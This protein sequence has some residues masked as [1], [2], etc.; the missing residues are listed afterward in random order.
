M[1]SPYSRVFLK[2]PLPIITPLTIAIIYLALASVW[3]VYSD[4]LL[5]AVIKKPEIITKY[6]TLKGLFFVLA[7]SLLIFI[8]AKVNESNVVKAR[9]ETEK[10]VINLEKLAE[11]SPTGILFIEPDGS[12]RFTN[13]MAERILGIDNSI[14][15]TLKYSEIDWGLKTMNGNEISES[16]RPFNKVLDTKESVFG[17]KYRIGEEG[18]YK[19]ISINAAPIFVEGDIIEGIACAI[20]DITDTV[21]SANSVREHKERYELLVDESP[22][23]VVIHQFNKIIS[24]NPM[25]LKLLQAES[26]EELLGLN[27]LEIIAPKYIQETLD[28]EA[29]FLRGE[30]L[31]FPFEMEIKSVKGNLVPIEII[32]IPFT[33]NNELAVQVVAI[34]ISDRLNKERSLE[35]ALAEKNV[36]L[37]E[38]HHR[39]K[40]NMA[41]ISGLMQLQ[42][43]EIEDK[44]L[45]GILFDGV[46]RIKTIA[47]IHEQLY[48]S[49]NF[50]GIK[51]DRNLKQMVS[52]V[53]EHYPDKTNL[54]I[55]YELEP[56]VLNI[57]QAVS[58]A[59]FINEAMSNLYKY[60]LEE[61]D[62]ATCIVGCNKKD[63]IVRL[64]L[65][66]NG[67]ESV[68][69]KLEMHSQ[70]LSIQLMGLMAN[71][72]Y[73]EMNLIK[74]T[75]GVLIEL[76]FDKEKK[77]KG[78]SESKHV[79]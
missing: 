4:S 48:E 6:Q 78:S 67:T 41:I 26:E 22:F 66:I 55:C 53:S 3:I 69:E 62:D 79:S 75:A 56:I 14:F 20:S 21:E 35:N 36:L 64:S 77:L 70:K 59:L 9:K 24:V 37:S 51:L 47:L 15:S 63:G 68:E 72:L 52:G 42:A 31:S 40:N 73:G 34:D 76:S 28:R 61:K 54:K 60:V 32:S 71:Q 18:N 10:E 1:K 39:V 17:A 27:I 11:A 65:Q 13:E 43:F 38:I 45:R 58:C 2:R 46:S 30:E 5:D 49:H 57:N 12:I 29:K 50:N 7:S 23:S 33:S 44:R 19:Y 16:E 25:G 8:L 74:N